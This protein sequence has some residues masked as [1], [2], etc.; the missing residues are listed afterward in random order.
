MRLE[1][2]EATL[3]QT[4]IDIC[5]KTDSNEFFQEIRANEN[6]QK[7]VR[8]IDHLKDLLRL[9]ASF[10]QPVKFPKL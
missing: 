10:C 6:C 7:F 9:E 2:V 1:P 8:F 4:M 5:S 3:A